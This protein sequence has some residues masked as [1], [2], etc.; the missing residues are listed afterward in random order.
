M[1][2]LHQSGRTA[3]AL[4]AGRAFRERMVDGLGVDPGP[5]LDD[6]QRRILAEDPA[7]RPAPAPEAPPPAA[8]ARRPRRPDR[9]V[10]RQAELAALRR[11]LG[12]G[13]VTTV[14]GPGGAGKTRLMTEALT[15]G[16]LVVELAELSVPADVPAAVAGALGLRAAPRGGVAAIIERLGSVPAVL[17]L[18][19]C[20]HLLD[21][22]RDL[23]DAVVA[24]CPGVR[25]LATSRQVRCPRPT[26]S[27]CSATG[28]PCCAP[29]SPLT[30]PA[31][32]SWPARCAGWSTACHSRSS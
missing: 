13:R 31:P 11:A 4:A 25:V 22:V 20:E 21:A 29:T 10:G 15:G 24:R 9:F 7:L 3:D 23:V 17:V 32:G 19:N 26:R 27:P 16:E 1:R 28:P 14:V 6:L 12:E 18:D 5:A 8:P 2:A 30:P